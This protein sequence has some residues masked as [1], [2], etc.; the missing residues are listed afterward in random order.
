MVSGNSSANEFCYL[1]LSCV[2]GS[3]T[4]VSF[5]T[6]DNSKDNFRHCLRQILTDLSAVRLPCIVMGSLSHDHQLVYIVSVGYASGPSSLASGG[7]VCQVVHPKLC[8]SDSMSSP[9]SQ[10]L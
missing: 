1:T 3:L 5:L 2:C 10:F 6:S 8:Q 7:V 9:S 4:L